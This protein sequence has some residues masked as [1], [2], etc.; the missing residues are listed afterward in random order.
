MFDHRTRFISASAAKK[1]SF[2]QATRVKKGKKNRIRNLEQQQVEASV[3][4]SIAVLLSSWP[5]KLTII[6][7]FWLI[8]TKS[9]YADSDSSRKISALP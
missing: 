2:A 9:T 5:W 1:T 7:A 6:G 4:H 8:S 3:M